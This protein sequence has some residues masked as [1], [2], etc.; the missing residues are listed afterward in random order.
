M[1][2]SLVVGDHLVCPREDARTGFENGRSYSSEDCT[3]ER[4]PPL[5]LV[6]LRKAIDFTRAV[7]QSSLATCSLI[8]FSTPRVVHLLTWDLSSTSRSRAML[9]AGVRYRVTLRRKGRTWKNS[10][11]RWTSCRPRSRRPTD[12]SW[13]AS[14]NEPWTPSGARTATRS[15]PTSRVG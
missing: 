7:V 9:A 13:T 1:P 14:W 4:T 3:L 8:V 6:P 11:R 12:G 15:S 5:R 2:L 10:P